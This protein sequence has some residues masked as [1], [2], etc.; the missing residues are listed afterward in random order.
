MAR[1]RNQPAGGEGDPRIA[2]YFAG[3]PFPLGPDGMPT[4]SRKNRADRCGVEYARAAW[5]WTERD[6]QIMTERHGS[7]WTDTHEICCGVPLPKPT[8]RG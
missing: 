6:E 3:N 7:E 2:A 1:R 5:G 4:G 8:G